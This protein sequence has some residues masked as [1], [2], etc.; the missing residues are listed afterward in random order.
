MGKKVLY[1]VLIIGIYIIL[2]YG[3]FQRDGLYNWLENGIHTIFIVVFYFLINY[4]FSRKTEKE[5]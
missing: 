3:D 1:P 5:N 2:V 4:I